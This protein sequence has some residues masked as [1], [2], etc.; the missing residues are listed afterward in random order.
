VTNYA[1]LVRRELAVY[2]V[3]PMAY[4]IL[5]AFLL[6][7][8]LFFGW[9]MDEF[10]AR[11][12]PVNYGWIQQWMVYLLTLIAPLITMRLIAEEKSRGTIETMMTAPVSEWQ[13]VLAKFSA[14]FLF[15]AYLLLPTVCYAILAAKFG[16]VD[17]GA[18]AA[19]YVGMLIA[20]AAVL[21]LG[22][23]ISATC[24]NQ[25]TAGVLTLIASLALIIMPMIARVLPQ[26]E[27]N[28]VFL[29]INWGV[30]VVALRGA[31][32]QMNLLGHMEAFSRGIVDFGALVY[33]LSVVGLFL[34]LTARIVESR[35]WR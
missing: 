10:A 15:V 6:V 26:G 16:T 13:F 1:A 8:G 17:F 22:L 21:A 2:F 20:V 27:V 11:R 4:I 25:I 30:F 14:A 19:G 23:C 12:S 18:A 32:H 24:A 9:S 35:R 7:N 31:L 29:G 33:F 3:S 28:A 5:T 34:F